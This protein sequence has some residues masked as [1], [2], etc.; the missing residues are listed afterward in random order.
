MEPSDE[1]LV[2]RVLDGSGDD[3]AVLVRRY[4]RIIYNL[5]YRFTANE[6]ESADLTQE[7]FIRSYSNLN[8]LK[9]RNKYFSWLYSIAMNRGRD[10]SKQKNMT[11]QKEAELAT[12]SAACLSSAGLSQPENTLQEKQDSL[13]LEKA[14]MSLS[15]KKREPLILR[16]RYEYSIREVAEIFSM[17]ESSVKMSIKRSLEQLNTILKKYL[18]A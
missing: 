14:L 11:L 1:E 4:E 8:R 16:Y 5:M 9:K 10:W 3:Y 12:S 18:S 7:I 15:P 6:M 17:S 13:L 2:A